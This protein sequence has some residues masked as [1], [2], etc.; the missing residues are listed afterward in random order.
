MIHNVPIMGKWQQVSD[1][2][3]EKMRGNGK[4]DIA[5]EITRWIVETDMNPLSNFLPHGLAWSGKERVLGESGLVIP[6]SSY[7]KEYGNDG[8]AFLNDWENGIVILLAGNQL[9][10]TTALMAKTALAVCRC[11]PSWPIFKYNKV[12]C[13]EWKGPRTWIVASYSWDNVKTLWRRMQETFPRIELGEYSPQWGKYSGEHGKGKDLTFGDGK[14]KSLDLKISNS[15]L[16]FL[17]YTQMQ[18]HWESFTSD[19]QSADEQEPEEKW[20]GWSRST[21]TRGFCQS[22][23]A[24]TGH[25][26]ADRPDTGAAGWFKR[27][28]WD[29]VNTRGRSVGRYHITI[30]SVPDA[31]ITP[32]KKLEAWHE[33]ADPD[34]PRTEKQKRAA[35]ARYWGGWEEGSGRVFDEF[36]R[37]IHVIN[38]IW[39]DDAVPRNWTKWRVIDY[40]DNGVTCCLWIALGPENYA[41]C[42]RV[43]YERGLLVAHT[44]K[45]VVEMSH[46][47]Y[48]KVN[49]ERNEITG[50]V[51]SVYEEIQ[52]NE[53]FYRSLLDSRSAATDKQGISL[54]QLFA[55]YGLELCEAS[56][57]RNEVQIPRLK[58]WLRIDYT[59]PHPWRKDENGNPVMGRPRLFFFDKICDPVISELEGL[60]KDPNDSSKINKKNPHHSVDCFV[61]GTMVTTDTGK[62]PVEKLVVGDNVLTRSGYHRIVAT[63]NSKKQI[64][65]VEV[66][67]GTTLMGSGEHPI[68]CIDTGTFVEIQYL[69][70]S[71]MVFTEDMVCKKEKDH[72]K[73][74]CS[75][76]KNG[77]DIQ[78][79]TDGLTDCILSIATNDCMYMFGKKSTD[80][81]PKDVISITKIPITETM[82]SPI[83][84][85]VPQKNILPIIPVHTQKNISNECTKDMINGNIPQPLKS[86]SVKQENGLVLLLKKAIPRA[87]SCVLGARKSLRQLIIPKGFCIA[88]KDAGS[89]ITGRCVNIKSNS[90]A[91]SVG[92]SISHSNIAR[93]KPVRVIAV[94]C[95]KEER[96]VYNITV[97]GTP[98]YFANG[99][100]VHNCLKYWSSDSP[101]WMGDLEEHEPEQ[102]HGR[103]VYGMP[104]R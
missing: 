44:S 96:N 17:C 35:V 1:E 33:W 57:Q 92:A 70:P 3:L 76:G 32:A 27:E 54:I 46:N 39:K 79:Q 6:P 55:R 83:S 14:P 98:E 52:T 89:P 53:K 91:L 73:L 20:V 30:E 94:S 59:L 5:D 15:R 4:A 81:S 90:S 25:E 26:L 49:E 29:G 88:T 64:W 48:S 42:Y 87:W 45:K 97:A 80:Q 74:C 95:L 21:R 7:P 9:G 50:E 58:D 66:S 99:I 11:D 22:I 65:K 67:D 19:G 43:I 93:I 41:V 13:P 69:K 100:L 8:V 23:H 102:E 60:Q 34:V 75:A 10:K 61:A 40:G 82:I 37:S 38:P 16:I 2:Q 51:Y 36:Y 84:N 63:H 71:M 31:I 62:V 68:L 47:R 78:N 103:S 28:V 86:I 77:T 101:C 56:G 85:V 72:A 104:F 24:M 18:M 12:I